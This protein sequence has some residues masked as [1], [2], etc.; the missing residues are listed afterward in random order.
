MKRIFSA[1]LGRACASVVFLVL[2]STVSSSFADDFEDMADTL[3]K[4]V[5]MSSQCICP[6]T[7]RVQ[8]ACNVVCGAAP[9]GMDTA[10]NEAFAQCMQTCF[11]H[12]TTI[13]QYNELVRK[14]QPQRSGLQ[15]RRSAPT[16]QA[17]IDQNSS[18]STLQKGREEAEAEKHAAD[19]EAEKRRRDE[20]LNSCADVRQDGH[21]LLLCCGSQQV[22]FQKCMDFRT[23]PSGCAAACAGN[24][25]LAN[26]R[27]CY[28]HW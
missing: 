3:K 4:C 17:K 27:H 24:A 18:A 11:A 20:A 26:G 7:E 15:P 10:R 12:Q 16:P 5:P 19:I 13:G 14:C 2:L 21:A 28:W 22:C 1:P 6:S 23:N 25:H 8:L 9:T